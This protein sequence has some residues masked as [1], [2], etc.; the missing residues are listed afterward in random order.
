M[1]LSNAVVYRGQLK[2]ASQSVEKAVLELPAWE[3][4]AAAQPPTPPWL[5]EVRLRVSCLQGDYEST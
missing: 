5:S 2:C 4:L 3:R 1:A